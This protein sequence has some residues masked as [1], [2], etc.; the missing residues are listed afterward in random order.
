MSTMT[1]ERFDAIMR[2]CVVY[3]DANRAAFD[4]VTDSK[5]DVPASI[6]FYMELAQIDA[7]IQVLIERFPQQAGRN[8]AEE[9]HKRGNVHDMSVCRLCV[10]H[11]QLGGRG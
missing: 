9:N 10:A 5:H 3:R 4:A 7:G 6:E 8:S 1:Q 11:R 2:A